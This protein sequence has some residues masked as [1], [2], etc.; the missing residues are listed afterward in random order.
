MLQKIKN[1]KKLR[2]YAKKDRQQVLGRLKTF[3]VVKI[4]FWW[5]SAK[6]TGAKIALFG[7]KYKGKS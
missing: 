6:F 4:Y 5:D 3:L 2:V 7:A 1:V